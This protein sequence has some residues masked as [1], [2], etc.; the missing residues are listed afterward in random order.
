[1]SLQ[2]P[3]FFGTTPTPEQWRLQYGGESYGPAILFS[4]MRASSI[5]FGCR[6]GPPTH[7]PINNY[8]TSVAL[9]L[10]N[11]LQLPLGLTVGTGYTDIVRVQQQNQL[12]VMAVNH[13]LCHT[14]P[15]ITRHELKNRVLVGQVIGAL[16]HANH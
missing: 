4:F 16:T 11:N 15:F 5:T 7:K 13:T 8:V 6:H 12:S 14:T 2:P 9:G 1:M 10:C 3:S